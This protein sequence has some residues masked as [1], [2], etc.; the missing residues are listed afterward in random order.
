VIPGGPG[1]RST[2]HGDPRGVYTAN[3]SSI[4]TAST[5][6]DHHYYSGPLSSLSPVNSGQVKKSSTVESLPIVSMEQQQQLQQQRFMAH[7]SESRSSLATTI[8]GGG[9][10][11]S[12]SEDTLDQKSDAASRISRV[13]KRAVCFIFWL[14]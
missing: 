6:R 1:D 10:A 3:S 11:R 5:S 9:M 13:R 14:V 7:N 8:I 12:S 4:S 2:V